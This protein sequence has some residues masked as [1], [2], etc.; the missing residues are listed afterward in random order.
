VGYSN[1]CVTMSVN[2]S[3]TYQD[4]G[5]GTVPVRNQAIVFQ[6]QLRTLGDTMIRSQLANISY[7]D[8]I[9]SH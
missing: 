4:T 1:E 6:L 2:Y 7:N 5:A 9:S 8:G 3:S